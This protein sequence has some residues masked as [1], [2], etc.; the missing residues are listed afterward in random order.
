[1]TYAIK[2]ADKGDYILML[3]KGEE[4]FLKLNGNEKTPYNEY[5]AVL[6]AIAAQ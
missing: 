5:E 6:E 3:G 1:M 2:K 4:H